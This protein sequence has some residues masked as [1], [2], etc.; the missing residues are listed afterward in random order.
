VLALK[1]ILVACEDAG[2]DP[3]D[4]DGFASYSNDR[5]EGLRLAGALG[6]RELRFSTMVWGGGGG[7]G[8]AAVANAAAAIHAGIADT[9]VVFRALAQG[10]F[11]RFGQAAGTAP[12]PRHSTARIS[13]ART[14]PRSPGGST[15]WPGSVPRTSTLSSRTRTS[16]AEWS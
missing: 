13:P 3:R 15:R 6:I 12:T 2:I 16:P 4:I 1:A 9:V 7:G 11:H 14:S 10:Q 8:S 5:N